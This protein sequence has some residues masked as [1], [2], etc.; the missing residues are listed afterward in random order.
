MDKEISLLV[1]FLLLVLDETTDYPLLVL[2]NLLQL[3]I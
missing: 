3:I 2:V 1:I